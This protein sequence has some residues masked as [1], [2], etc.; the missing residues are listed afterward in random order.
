M[1]QLDAVVGTVPE[2]RALLLLLST[3]EAAFYRLGG[4]ATPSFE[5]LRSVV[6]FDE[7][8]RL[9]VGPA[10]D[11]VAAAAA[12]AR[13]VAVEEASAVMASTVSPE[14]ACGDRK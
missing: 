3:V 8:G 14:T 13:A 12:E 9:L 2:G 4:P 11:V 7:T 6:F 10:A 1:G 5:A